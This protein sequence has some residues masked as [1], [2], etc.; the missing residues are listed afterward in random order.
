MIWHD[1]SPSSSCIFQWFS[2]R[3]EAFSG[4]PLPPVFLQP[5]ESFFPARQRRPP[6]LKLSLVSKRVDCKCLIAITPG[7]GINN[8]DQLFAQNRPTTRFSYPC[9]N[10]AAHYFLTILRY[11]KEAAFPLK[12]DTSYGSSL[13]ISASYCPL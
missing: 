7:P 4:L 6:F 10:A 11:R 9:G 5:E 3:P 8:R 2:R 13:Q 12:C 1:C